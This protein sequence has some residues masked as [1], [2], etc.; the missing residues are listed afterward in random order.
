MHSDSIKSIAAALIKARGNMRNAPKNAQNPHLRNRYADLE[1]VLE[2]TLA[3]LADAGIAV[4]QMPESDTGETVSV[5]TMLVHESGEWI[6][7]SLTLKPAT[8]YAKDGKSLGVTPQAVGSAIT[9]A[10]RYTLAALCALTQTDDDADAASRPAPPPQRAA[11]AT[12]PAPQTTDANG[13]TLRIAS[14]Q[15]AAELQSIARDIA[16][17]GISGSDRDALIATW[18]ERLAAVNAQ[19]ESAGDA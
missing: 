19:H 14:A 1:S 13:W 3:P 12:Q 8:S 2:A 15:T 6:S 17:A 16:K 11:H 4:V 18:R 7:S 5:S 9:Y 10:R